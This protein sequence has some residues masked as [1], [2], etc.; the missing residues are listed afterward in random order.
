MKFYTSE[1]RNH[2]LALLNALSFVEN[3][4]K[5]NVVSKIVLCANTQSN[6]CMVD[7]V[8]NELHSNVFT[9]EDGRRLNIV[10]YSLT[11]YKNSPLCVNDIVISC[12]MDSSSLFV[13]DDMCPS[14]LAV[15][16]V[17]W[18]RDVDDWIIRWNAK[19]VDGK[20]IQLNA[21]PKLTPKAIGA[22][23]NLDAINTSSIVMHD[24]DEE[25]CKTIVRALYK[26]EPNTDEKAVTD[27][28]V[29]EQRW[30]HALAKQ[31]GDL[32][33]KLKMGKRFKGGTGQNLKSWYDKW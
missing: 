11:Q 9:T 7:E 18:N 6:Y 10:K 19:E 32:F 29:V 33:L 31:V 21:R 25:L 22:M 26:Y 30:R 1:L 13:I 16:A 14:P 20:P 4:A 27:F 3:I 5:D 8:L 2:K 17:P 23:R 12:F 28:L 15:I 24:Y